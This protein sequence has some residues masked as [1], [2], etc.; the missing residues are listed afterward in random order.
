M[1]L[2]MYITTWWVILPAALG[3][4][5]TG[6]VSSLG[7]AW[8]LIR[9]YWVIVKLSI[10]VLS[11]LA[12]LVHLRPIDLLAKSAASTH[13]WSADLGQAQVMMAAASSAALLALLALTAL[14]VYKPRGVTPRTVPLR[15]A[16][17]NA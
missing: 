4:L 1:Y 11:T 5:V 10:T 13:A 9:H 12:L 8:G 17:V 14:S 6:V 15:R 3:S 7:T 16:R 2:A